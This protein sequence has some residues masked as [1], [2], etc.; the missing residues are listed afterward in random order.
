M[1]KKLQL[2]LF[3]VLLASAG[4]MAAFVAKP[5]PVDPALTAMFAADGETFTT[6]DF[7]A[8]TPKKIRE[9]TGERLGLKKSVALKL[10][11]R[12]VKKDLKRQAKAG[13]SAPDGDKSQLVAL[14]LALL[15]GG[16]GIHSFYMGKT[17]K[18]ILQI[19]LLLTSFLIVPGILLLAWLLYDIIT[20]ATGSQE[21]KNGVWDPAL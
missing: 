20:I 18:G 11:Q 14:L 10:A 15:I 6:D 8:L 4:L 12:A 17:L 3:V 9:K 1:L 19:V 2:S 13:I 21:P 16:L 7:L 5:M